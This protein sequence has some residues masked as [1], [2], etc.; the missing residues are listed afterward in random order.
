M[1]TPNRIVLEADYSGAGI[2]EMAM[3]VSH[4]FCVLP[5]ACSSSS[6]LHL[7]LWPYASYCATLFKVCKSHLNNVATEANTPNSSER[8][9]VCAFQDSHTAQ[10]IR[11]LYER[12]PNMGTKRYVVYTTFLT[13]LKGKA[14]IAHQ[15]AIISSILTLFGKQTRRI[16]LYQIKIRITCINSFCN[17]ILQNPLN[18]CGDV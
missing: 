10:R 13:T 11:C 8:G 15:N 18:R 9:R 12:G 14:K 17:V 7:P 1:L 2:N 5:C 3:L 4:S 6:Q 16:T